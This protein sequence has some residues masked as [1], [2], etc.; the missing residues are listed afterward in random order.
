MRHSILA[1]C[2]STIKNGEDV[3]KKSCIIPSSELVLEMLK[4]MQKEGYIGEFE[5]IEDGKGNKIKVELIG[6]IN[7]CKVIRPRFSVKK[8][9]FEKWEKRYLPAK[10]FG[11]LLVSTSKGVMTH[12][13][14]RD[15][16]IGG[17][18]M[19]YIY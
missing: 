3:G 13:E 19:A 15:N 12:E 18:L 5:I 16:E 11:H 1:D 9:G 17:K 14:A 4:K 6:Q 10:G 2:F 7:N 8:D